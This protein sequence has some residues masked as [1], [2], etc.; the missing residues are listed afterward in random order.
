MDKRKRWAVQEIARLSAP[1]TT[2]PLPLNP[3]SPEKSG[4][5]TA[6]VTGLE[7]AADIL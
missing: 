6:E 5:G 2:T 7:V 1:L 4:L 3:G